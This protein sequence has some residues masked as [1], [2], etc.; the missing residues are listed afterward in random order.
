MC[1]M[2][3]LAIVL[4]IG[5]S[6]AFGICFVSIGYS[7]LYVCACSAFGRRNKFTTWL[8]LFFMWQTACF[9]VLWWELWS[10]IMLF[11]TGK[12]VL[13]VVRLNFVA[14][15]FIAYQLPSNLTFMWCLT[16]CTYYSCYSILEIWF[17]ANTWIWQ[18][19]SFPGSIFYI[20][21]GFA[22]HPQLAISVNC[23]T[24]WK[25]QFT[26]KAVRHTEPSFSYANLT[27]ILCGWNY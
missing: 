18:K 26:F 20:Q 10:Y 9:V 19:N 23:C 7:N 3:L 24:I 11:C 5:K 2:S 15:I 12:I 16:T 27:W 4:T 13:N 6:K 25:P 1:S 17:K 14:E 21:F 22:S 8:L